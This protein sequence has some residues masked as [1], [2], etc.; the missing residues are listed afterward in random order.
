MPFLC[1]RLIP[2]P[3]P[4][5]TPPPH[6]LGTLSHDSLLHLGASISSIGSSS[7]VTNTSRHPHLR[8]PPWMDLRFEI[9]SSEHHRHCS[10]LSGSS[11]VS[12]SAPAK[13]TLPR[14]PTSYLPPPPASS[15]ILMLM[16]HNP[17]WPVVH[18]AK[19]Q[20]NL[21]QARHCARHWGYKGGQDRHGSLTWCRLQSS[22]LALLELT[23][24][25]MGCEGN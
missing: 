20:G 10:H 5:A 13:W 6:A 4:Q 18:S 21:L 15:I 12:F 23:D 1:S 19:M 3:E 16:T 17:I 24:S 14:V 25:D 11:S 8:K 2:T 22:K 7:S 9:P